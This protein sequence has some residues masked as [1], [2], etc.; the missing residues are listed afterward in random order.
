[1]II[2]RQKMKAESKQ[3]EKVNNDVINNKNSSGVMYSWLVWG[4][5]GN[6]C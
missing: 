1:M 6:T 4:W 5:D 2:Q 3:G